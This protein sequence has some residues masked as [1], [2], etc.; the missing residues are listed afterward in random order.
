VVAEGSFESTSAEQKE[1]KIASFSI[2][3][4]RE[5]DSWRIAELREFSRVPTLRDLAWLI[6]EWSA[7]SE[8][9]TRPR[10]LISQRFARR[11]DPGVWLF[12]HACR[13]ETSGHGARTKF[14]HRGLFFRVDRTAAIFGWAKP[15][16]RSGF[17]QVAPASAR[18][19]ML[20]Q[21][22][23]VSFGEGPVVPHAARIKNDEVDDAS[24]CSELQWRASGAISGK[25]TS[26]Q[27]AARLASRSSR[28]NK[29]RK[30]AGVERLLAISN[31]SV[32]LDLSVSAGVARSDGD[33]FPAG[34]AAS[35]NASKTRS[36]S[37]Q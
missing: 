9:G 25:T 8:G 33:W 17:R 12:E 3:Y 11:L 5:E 16:L 29:V 4:I 15:P 10:D 1:L 30:H 35:A 18:A 14:G 24:R 13:I 23:L 36:G 22:A 27:A 28:T 19:N 34:I 31:P 6:G 20:Y 21:M 32:G 2:L 26:Q 7:K 37:R